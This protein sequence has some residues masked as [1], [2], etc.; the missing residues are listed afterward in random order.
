MKKGL[1]GLLF[2]CVSSM[3]VWAE[4]VGTNIE[5]ALKEQA[6]HPPLYQIVRQ[7]LTTYYE[8]ESFA[9]PSKKSGWYRVD[10]FLKWIEKNEKILPDTP[11]LWGDKTVLLKDLYADLANE[12]YRSLFWGYLGVRYIFD[13]WDLDISKISFF[14]CSNGV[15]HKPAGR[16]I[17]IGLETNIKHAAQMI[18][19]GMH[20]AA[21]AQHTWKVGEFSSCA[22]QNSYALPVKIEKNKSIGFSGVRDFRVSHDRLGN[23]GWMLESEYNECVILPF[24]KEWAILMEDTS[25]IPL[26]CDVLKSAFPK[27][28]CQDC[29]LTQEDVFPLLQQVFGPSVEKYQNQ[30]KGGHL[31]YAGIYAPQDVLR[32]FTLY[33]Q[34]KEEYISDKERLNWEFLKAVLPVSS[35]KFTLYFYTNQEKMTALFSNS[36]LSKDII[37]DALPLGT[38]SIPFKDRLEKMEIFYQ[39]ILGKYADKNFKCT[40]VFPNVVQLLDQ[41]AGPQ[42]RSVVPEGYI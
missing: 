41:L 7:E 34:G 8:R 33:Y 11:I 20:E 15:C 35:E 39:E 23:M 13:E 16:G 37:H 24:F 26:F 40:D 4:S 19:I 9:D 27:P 25:K 22:T 17:S 2:L 36:D 32:F 18:N 14:V 38:Y 28:F 12:D 29:T 3:F 21:H 42:T 31:V 30:A 5:Q 1:V 6:A 10:N